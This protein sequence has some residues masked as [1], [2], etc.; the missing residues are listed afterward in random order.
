MRSLHYSHAP[1]KT[2]RRN[3][4]GSSTALKLSTD[5]SHLLLALS[6]NIYRGLWSRANRPTAPAS[7]G[8]DRAGQHY[9]ESLDHVQ[10]SAIRC[11]VVR[12]SVPSTH[13]VFHG[14]P[15][16][17]PT[18]AGASALTLSIRTPALDRT[19]VRKISLCSLFS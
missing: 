18:S 6:T 3:V 16:V 15:F 14:G 8:H 10:C 17:S 7:L 12:D 19:I 1:Y 4:G 5:T 13:F 9:I 11:I 2:G